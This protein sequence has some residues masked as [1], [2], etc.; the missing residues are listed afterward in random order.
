MSE[1]TGLCHAEWRA[2]RECPHEKA[3]P[4]DHLLHV[5][6]SREYLALRLECL[7]GDYQHIT[8]DQESSD[9]A[10]EQTVDTETCWVH[11][12]LAECGVDVLADGEWAED[13]P[14]PVHCRWTGDGL[15]IH[16]AGRQ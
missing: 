10:A 1:H 12:W 13:G 11:E 14:W 4:A 2:D 15:L 9:V 3:Q 8:V 16:P 5:Q 7:P 6:P